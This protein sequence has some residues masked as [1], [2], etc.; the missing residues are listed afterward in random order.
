MFLLLNLIFVLY[1]R[2][3]LITPGPAPLKILI[4]NGVQNAELNFFSPLRGFFNLGCKIYFLWITKENFFVSLYCFGETGVR[5]VFN[6]V[7]KLK[8]CKCR[9]GQQYR[10]HGQ[11]IPLFYFPVNNNKEYQQ[12][13]WDV[14]ENELVEVVFHKQQVKK[15]TEINNGMSE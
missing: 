9:S 1:E 13:H 2:Y 15:Q 14:H 12:E 6:S 3:L 4:P 7:D 10:Q 8:Y 11:H 5:V